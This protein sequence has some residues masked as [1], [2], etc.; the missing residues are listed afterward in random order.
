MGLSNE[1]SCEAG[2]FSHHHNP[3]WFLQSEALFPCAGTLSCTVCLSPQLFLL[4]H[5]H[6]I[7]GPP[8]PPTTALPQV[9]STLTAHLHHP[10]SLDE[11][12][13]FSSLVL[14]LPYSSDFWHFW[15]FFVFKL[16]VIFRLVMQG[17]KA[18]LPIP[19]SW[20]EAK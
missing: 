8:G 14:G 11:C 13:F 9:L 18:Y 1:V 15:L 4:V 7:M 20:S 17:C 3:D 19:P 2:S 6:T 16:V 5:P 12:F 10:T